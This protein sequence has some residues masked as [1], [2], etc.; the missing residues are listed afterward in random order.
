MVDGA[1]CARLQEL[2]YRVISF[3]PP[4]MFNT[5]RTPELTMPEMVRCAVETLEYFDIQ[6]PVKLLGHS[7]GGMISLAF[8]LD[9]PGRVSSQALFASLSGGPAITRNRGLPLSL[10]WINGDFWRLLTYGARLMYGRG[11]LALHKKMLNLLYRYSYADHR[12]APQVE[13]FAEDRHQPAPV[14][15]RWPAVA[16][17]IDF[18]ERLE[19]IRTP[20]LVGVGRHDPQTPVACSEEIARDI[21]GARL[22]I[23]ENSGHNLFEEEPEKFKHTLTDFGW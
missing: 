11:S 22:V 13:I 9:Y 18:L 12:Q 1:L 16:L 5:T 6:V 14:R 15:D 17:R 19:E 4:G 21:P 23:F 2:G 10:P 7:M 8:T 3:D 20:T